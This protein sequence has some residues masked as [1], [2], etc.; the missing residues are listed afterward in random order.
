[1]YHEIPNYIVTLTGGF[2]PG[3]SRARRDPGFNLLHEADVRSDVGTEYAVALTFQDGRLRYYLDG[4]RIHDVVDSDPPPAGRFALR[5]WS[6]N[7]IWDDVE[8]GRLVTAK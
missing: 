7:A 5:T 8:F 6:T 1:L 2:Q 3:W 4:K